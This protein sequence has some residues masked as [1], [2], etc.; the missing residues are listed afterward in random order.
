MER[1]T[2]VPGWDQP[3]PQG[4]VGLHCGAAQAANKGRGAREGTN[5]QCP[6]PGME[7]GVANT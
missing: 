3:Q 5:P 2:E 1:V 6:W 7:G 4:A